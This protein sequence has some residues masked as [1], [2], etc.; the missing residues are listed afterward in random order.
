MPDGSR[1]MA[2]DSDEVKMTRSVRLTPSNNTVSEYTL[3]GEE[4]NRSTFR[5]LLSSA[6]ASLTDTISSPG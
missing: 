2:Y 4:S 1:R 5:R 3:N 6:N